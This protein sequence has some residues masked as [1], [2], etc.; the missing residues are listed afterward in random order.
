MIELNSTIT[1]PECAVQTK[2]EMQTDACL[3]FFEGPPIQ[4]GDG[5]CAA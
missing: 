1:C 4:Q 2:K 3:F 5:F